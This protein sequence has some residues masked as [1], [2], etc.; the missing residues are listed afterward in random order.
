[1]TAQRSA[2][3]AVQKENILGDNNDHKKG[4]KLEDKFY[5]TQK[6]TSIRKNINENKRFKLKKGEKEKKE[7]KRKNKREGKIKKE[8]TKTRKKR[9]K[10]VSFATFLC[11]GKS[12]LGAPKKNVD[13]SPKK[14]TRGDK[15]R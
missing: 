10:H 12:I 1:M 11:Y 14:K 13:R 7:N 9:P 4:R 6:Q 5:K 15:V 2:L 3:I 8:K